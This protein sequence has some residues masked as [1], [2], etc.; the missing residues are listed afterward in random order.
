MQIS[1]SPSGRNTKSKLGSG[2]PGGKDGIEEEVKVPGKGS[3]KKFDR[4]ASFRNV[5]FVG[6]GDLENEHLPFASLATR[7]WLLLS[8]NLR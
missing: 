4:K 2:G 7:C 8:Y 1:K 3:R 6:D 5:S